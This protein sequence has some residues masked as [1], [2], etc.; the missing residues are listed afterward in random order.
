MK[1]DMGG[2][3]TITGG[4]GSSDWTYHQAYQADHLCAVERE[5]DLW[6][7]IEAGD[8]IFTKMVRLSE[9]MN[10]DAEGRLVL[11]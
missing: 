7:C 11:K 10:T 6:S 9:I 5:H 1:A 2:A 3:A 4:L 8:I